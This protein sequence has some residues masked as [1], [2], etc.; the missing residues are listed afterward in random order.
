[1]SQAQ[2]KKKKKARPGTREDVTIDEMPPAI[3]I[4]LSEERWAVAEANF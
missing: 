4:K 2:K 3:I 1:L